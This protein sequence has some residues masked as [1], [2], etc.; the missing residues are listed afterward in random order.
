M[1]A[2]AAVEEAV[3]QRSLQQQLQQRRSQRRRARWRVPR[4]R[5]GRPRQLQHDVLVAVR[6]LSCWHQQL[7]LQLELVMVGP[8]CCGRGRASPHVASRPRGGKVPPRRRRCRGAS[9]ARAHGPP[10]SG[11]GEA[12]PRHP[13]VSK[14]GFFMCSHLNTGFTCSNG[15][16]IHNRFHI[17]LACAIAMAKRLVA[18]VA[19]A[20]IQNRTRAWEHMQANMRK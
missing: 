19:H 6:T 12:R 11:R 18:S 2:G 17:V 3:Q 15:F 5:D 8:E 1:V 20:Q 10:R 7:Q 16:N 14:L 9:R 13:L 4:A